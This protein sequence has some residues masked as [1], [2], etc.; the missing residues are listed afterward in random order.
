M[1]PGR[2][3]PSRGDTVKVFNMVKFLTLGMVDFLAFVCESKTVKFSETW[4]G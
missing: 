3:T 4:F 2:F 1:N